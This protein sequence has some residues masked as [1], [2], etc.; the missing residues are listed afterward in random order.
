MSSVALCCSGASACS[1][2]KGCQLCH[3]LARA[4]RQL[5]PALDDV[6]LKSKVN[7]SM[8]A[9]LEG[10]HTLATGSSSTSTIP[11]AS[12]PGSQMRTATVTRHETAP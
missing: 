5:G 7:S 1:S 6:G 11:A 4:R 3:K 2:G 8:V 10:T 9:H 12:S